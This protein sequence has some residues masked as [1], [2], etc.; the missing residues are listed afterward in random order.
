VVREDGDLLVVSHGARLP[1]VCVRCG[2]R[3]DIVR[4]LEVMHHARPW[5]WLLLCLGVL[6]VVAFSLLQR[7]AGVVLPICIVCD[8]RWRR[9]VRLRN[10]A[11]L[12]M[13]PIS[14]LAF[15]AFAAEA[16]GVLPAGGGGGALAV[17]FA[18]VAAWAAL[19]AALRLGKGRGL[20]V[21]AASIDRDFLFLR[22]VPAEARR[23]LVADA[24][25][26]RRAVDA[27]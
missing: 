10:W 16:R 5:T 2:A 4:R 1:D 15:G 12:A 8:A 11:T 3:D 13:L 6:G 18:L 20:T 17:L 25:A 23:A 21:T 14:L 27:T 26:V 19:M 24:A 9:I 7:S 22:G